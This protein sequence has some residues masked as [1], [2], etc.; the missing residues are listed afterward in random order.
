MRTTF[1]LVFAAVFALAAV[2]AGA[3]TTLKMALVVPIDSAEGKGA[4]KLKE[5]VEEK[6]G[7]ELEIVIYPGAQLGSSYE[8]IESQTAGSIEMA[9]HG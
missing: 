9:L 6:P 2:P 8:I 1:S 3:K 7:G 5:L 4:A